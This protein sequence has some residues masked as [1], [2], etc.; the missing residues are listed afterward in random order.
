MKT[1]DN[2]FRWGRKALIA[3]IVGTGLLFGGNYIN[4]TKRDDILIKILRK[5]INKEI[6]TREQKEAADFLEEVL[7]EGIKERDEQRREEER[8]NEIKSYLENSKK[9][10][11][12]EKKSLGKYFACNYWKDFNQDGGANYPEEYVGIKEK[13]REDEKIT[14]VSYNV[15]GKSWKEEVY[16]PKGKKIFEDKMEINPNEGI[17]LRTSDDFDMTTWLVQRGGYGNYKAVW[18]VDD[19][20]VGS[21]EFEII[22]SKRKKIL[23][24]FIMY[25]DI[26]M[27]EWWDKNKDNHISDDERYALKK[28]INLDRELM[29]IEFPL[30]KKGKFTFKSWD[31]K[32]K[33]IGE[34]VKENNENNEGRSHYYHTVKDIK[35]I[36]QNNMDF[37]DK[38]RL[39]GP[40]K[41]RI[42]VDFEGEKG[43]NLYKEFNVEI[44]N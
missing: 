41:Y 43:E 4:A 3:S 1:I 33:L 5:G 39:E 10:E 28:E 32:G 42:T 22:P 21:T 23:D 13:F 31:G 37:I 27:Y 16:D 9:Q 25:E 6:K 7:R 11:E 17:V 24:N 29:V 2:I 44:V 19:K 8:R 36:D 20:Y 26:I 34:T 30:Y 40:G 14:L 12:I 15:K 18:S 35:K 38:L